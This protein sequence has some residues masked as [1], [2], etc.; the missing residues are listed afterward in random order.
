[1]QTVVCAGALRPCAAQAHSTHTLSSA[2]AAAAA[3]AAA[4]PPRRYPPPPVYPA[5]HVFVNHRYKFIYLRHPKAA[6]TSLLAFFGKCE[7]GR[8]SHNSSCI[9]PLMVGCHSFFGWQMGGARGVGWGGPAPSICVLCS[10]QVQGVGGW[11]ARGNQRKQ[12]KGCKVL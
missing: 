4:A 5:C 12:S 1:M 8:T 3:G 6:S 11:L 7:G 10:K 2:P 9:E